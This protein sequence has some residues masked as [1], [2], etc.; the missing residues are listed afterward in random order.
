[1]RVTKVMLMGLLAAMTTLALTLGGCATMKEEMAK[2]APV[3]KVAC[4]VQGKMV[5][6]VAPE[7]KLV[8][9][10]CMHK[11]Y[12]G[13]QSL[14]VKVS[15]KNVSSEPQR[16]RV[17]IFLDNDKAVGGLIPRKTKK[18]LVKPGATASFTYFFK[19]QS[20]PPIGMTLIVKTM[21]K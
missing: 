21:A 4:A 3:K 5:R 13:K 14:A 11:M 17:N 7:A 15:L 19:G 8:G 12:D 6:A 20:T 2:P 9:L 10:E 1:M 18:G 16:F